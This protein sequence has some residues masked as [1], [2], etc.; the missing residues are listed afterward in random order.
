MKRFLIVIAILIT[1]LLIPVRVNA[2]GYSVV[3]DAGHGGTETGTTQCPT[4]VEKDANLKIALILQPMLQK[5]GYT[6]YMTR[7]T[8]VTLTN[9]QRYNFAN[10]TN[11]QIFV[12]VHLNSSTNHTKDG[13]EGLYGKRNKDL[14]LTKTVHA[15]E[16]TE[17]G[18][19]DLGVTN[20]ADGILLKT[21]MPATLTES[22]FLSNTSECQQLSDGS[23][24]RETQI[25]QALFDGIGN[26]FLK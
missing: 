21:T 16:A 4:L 14:A 22:V 26:Y 5:A 24:V 10:S 23:N 9:A 17:L 25:A 6:V 2:G 12:S 7:T 20:F 13:T 15:S 1:G 18:I 8:D 19:P 3:L 11:A